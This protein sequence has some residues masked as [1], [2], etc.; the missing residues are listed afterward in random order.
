MRE[1]ARLVMTER[2]PIVAYVDFESLTRIVSEDRAGSESAA[3]FHPQE[4]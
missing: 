2:E 1:G 4:P 3:L